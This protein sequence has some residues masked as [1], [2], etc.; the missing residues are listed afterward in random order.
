MCPIEVASRGW[1]PLFGYFWQLSLRLSRD[2][3]GAIGRQQ[4]SFSCGETF[5]KSRP[6]LFVGDWS[7]PCIQR[8]K[9]VFFFENC[10]KDHLQSLW[11]SKRCQKNAL[12]L[13]VLL[14]F[15]QKSNIFSEI[16]I[17][18]DKNTNVCEVY[19]WNLVTFPKNIT[20]YPNRLSKLVS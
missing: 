15:W 9:K 3:D 6:S 2:F 16:T 13:L 4:I 20:S 17:L 12:C 7:Y 5:C 18:E 10:K 19:S 14:L 8:R 1:A 11:T